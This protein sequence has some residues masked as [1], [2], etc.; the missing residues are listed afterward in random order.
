MIATTKQQS[1]SQWRR[2]RHAST[3]R[4]AA[5]LWLILFLPIL[6]VILL[7]VVEVGNLTLARGQLENSVEASAK[8]AVQTWYNGGGGDTTTARDVGQ[9]FASYNR[10]GVSQSV[11]LN[12]NDDGAGTNPN[13]NQALT[14]ANANLIFGRVTRT[15]S[16]YVFEG[17]VEPRISAGTIRVVASGVFN[18]ASSAD[19]FLRIEFTSPNPGLT[20]IREVWIDLQSGTEPG[21]DAAFFANTT[22]QTS[23]VPATVPAGLSYHF[24]TPPT[25][26]NES[27]GL[28]LFFFGG[29][30]LRLVPASTTFTASTTT[31]FIRVAGLQ[32]GPGPLFGFGVLGAG[33]ASGDGDAFGVYGIQGSVVLQDNPPGGPTR[34]V[35]F[36]FVNDGIDNGRSEVSFDAGRTDEIFGVR[37]AT[38]AS[39][40][41]FTGS[42]LGVPIG[43]FT[44]KAEAVA[45]YDPTLT[46]VRVKTVRINQ[47]IPAAISTS[48]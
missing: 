35:P 18:N 27:T 13:D 33:S 15:G 16:N 3:R 48:P 8:A 4:G 19:D 24:G 47:Y 21:N 41:S 39:I 30:T 22:S 12:V 25:G 44:M 34:V 38:T 20:V 23:S 6:L 2:S 26:A 14:G 9:A 17:N 28:V 11:S 40:P 42:L 45:I 10:I 7:M 1:N 43:P 37:S 36:T 5:T 31:N 29:N 32:V 46:G